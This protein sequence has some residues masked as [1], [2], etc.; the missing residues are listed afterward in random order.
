M[1]NHKPNK[2][3]LS[4]VPKFYNR[5][6]FESFEAEV[7]GQGPNF[8]QVGKLARLTTYERWM[9]ILI[10]PSDNVIDY[11]WRAWK[12]GR[13]DPEIQQ[14]IKDSKQEIPVSWVEGDMLIAIH[15]CCDVGV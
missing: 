10:R 8:E 12:A 11:L 1:A 6:R 5:P 14:A 4:Q 9:R 15:D 13:L 3:K 7:E 2:P